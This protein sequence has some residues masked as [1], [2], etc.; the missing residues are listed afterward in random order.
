MF[1]RAAK[2]MGFN[3]ILSKS[4]SSAFHSYF[5]AD[6]TE[7]AVCYNC[8]DEICH[9]YTYSPADDGRFLFAGGAGFGLSA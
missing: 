6:V 7:W 2:R 9:T 3:Q 8:P 5:F 4:G 1:L